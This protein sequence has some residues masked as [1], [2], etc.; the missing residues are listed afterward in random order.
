MPLDARRLIALVA[1]IGVFTS[2]VAAAANERGPTPAR[3]LPRSS[4][5]AK[6]RGSWQTI[7]SSSAPERLAISD[8]V[9][10]ASLHWNS[11]ASGVEWTEVAVAGTGEAWRTRVIAA[12]I[13]PA[14]VRLTLDTATHDGGPAWTVARTPDDAAIA[15]NAG[16]FLQSKPWGLVVLNGTTMLSA[17]TGPLAS[18]IWFDATGGVHLSHAG[19]APPTRATFAFQSYPTLVANGET[20]APLR[21]AGLG[22]DVAHRDARAAVGVD[23]AGRVIIVMTRFDALGEIFGS[24]P[25]GLTTPEMAG[26]MLAFGAQDAVMLDGGISAQML[27][28]DADGSAHR[29]P[30]MRSVPLAVIGRAISK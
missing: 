18:T 26:L 21:Q 10:G 9:F 13:D 1:A 12:R 2:P 14:R 3:A 17:G 4:I 25:F 27:I 7:W 19:Q 15:F 30:G 8:S 29:W 6:I 11:G 28:R 24:V 16:Q 20:P 22:I 5:A 23:R